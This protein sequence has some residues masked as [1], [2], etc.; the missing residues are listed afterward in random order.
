METAK[1]KKKAKKEKRKKKA[2][3]VFCILPPTSK[4]IL[5]QVLG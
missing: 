3:G 4:T 2:Q 1:K 5:D